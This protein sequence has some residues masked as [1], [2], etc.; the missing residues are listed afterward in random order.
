[1]KALGLGP[2]S[3]W[4]D[5]G[6]HLGGRSLPA[7]WYQRWLRGQEYRD[8]S[9]FSAS[10]PKG[11]KLKLIGGGASDGYRGGKIAV[12]DKAKLVWG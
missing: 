8:A 9:S 2:L 10:C 12:R 6:T 3:S 11:W 7:S 1:M 5:L 4:G